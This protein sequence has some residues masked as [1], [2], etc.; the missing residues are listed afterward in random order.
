MVILSNSDMFEVRLATLLA[1]YDRETLTNLYQPIIGY[2]SLAVYFTLWSEANNQKVNSLGTHEELLLRMKIATGEFIE[3]RKVLEAVGLVKTRLE[4]A[5][6]IAIY[7]YE[8]HAPKTPAGFFNDTLLYGLFLQNLGETNASKIKRVYELDKASELGEDVTTSFNDIFHPDF[9]DAAF[10]QASNKTNNTLGRVKG[11]IDT[12]FSFEKFFSYL[13]EISQINENSL[14]KKELKEIERLT[15]LYGLN[16]EIAASSVAK[17]YLPEGNK[18]K[19]VD[20][21]ALNEDFKNTLSYKNYSRARNNKKNFVLG[22]NGLAAKIKLFEM[23]SPAE[24][25]SYLRNNTKPAKADLN[26]IYSLSTNYNLPNAVINVIVDYVLS[27]NDNIL[28]S[29]K[30]EQIAAS[31]AGSNI[32]TAVDAM[33]YLKTKFYKKNGT[34]KKEFIKDEKIEE[35]VEEIKEKESNN[36]DDDVLNF[37]KDW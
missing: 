36:K 11:K 9:E 26:V 1:D 18:G 14:T 6:G 28:S 3:A 31:F 32:V 22:D 10:M 21:V 13:S 15:S 7:H 16:E 29:Y 30:A 33:E 2:Q 19:R 23:K 17:V 35:K 4:K 24:V 25:L 27:T 34:K 37:F 12:E 5:H 8:L 20:L